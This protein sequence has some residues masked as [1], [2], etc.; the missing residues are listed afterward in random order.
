MNS[1]RN[2]S[3]EWNYRRQDRVPI[4]NHKGHA[5]PPKKWTWQKRWHPLLQKRQNSR[6]TK[7]RSDIKKL[8][9]DRGVMGGREGLSGAGVT[10][11]CVEKGSGA[12]SR[13]A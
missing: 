1:G 13:R 3:H 4:P 12:V 10:E 11:R 5:L 8:E 6:V 7:T 2:P 9:R